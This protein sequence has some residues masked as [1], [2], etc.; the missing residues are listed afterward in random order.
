MKKNLLHVVIA[1]S[2][3]LIGCKT[4]KSNIEWSITLN[5]PGKQPQQVVILPDNFMNGFKLS[6]D[7]GNIK[8]EIQTVSK[9]NY[10]V[11]NATATL[12]KGNEANC[13]LALQADYKSGVAWNYDGEVKRT[14]VFRQSPH[15]VNAWIT[16]S[17][18]KQAMPVI[19][20][21]SADGFSIAVS[22]SPVFYDN[23]TAQ[24]FDIEKKTLL[25]MSGDA[26]L[27]PG[28]KPETMKMGAYNAEKGQIFTPGTVRPYYHKISAN[29]PH[30]FECLV[31]NSKAADLNMLRKDIV[32][33]AAAHWSGGKITDYMG[34][35]AFTVPYMNLRKNE[36]AKSKY[37]VIPSVEYANTQYCRDAF[38]ISTMLTDSMSAEC[39]K[40]ELDSV[41][42]YAEYPLYIPI[43]AYRNQLKGMPVD[44]AKVQQY[45][46][47]IE[48]HI[49]NGSYYSYDVNDGRK[50]FQYWNDCF[51]FD[52]TDVITYN[53][54]LLA[55][56][57]MAAEKM[58]LTL[59]TPSS[60][61]IKRYQSLYNSK[62]GFYPISQ[63]KDSVLSP[64]PLFGDLLAQIYFGTPILS[65]ETIQNHYNKIVQKSKTPFGYKI[66]SDPSG[67]YLSNSAYD[68]GSYQSQINVQNMPVG[69]YQRGGSWTLYDNLFLVDCYLHNIKGAEEELIWRGTLDFKLGATTFECINTKTGEPLKPNM[70]WNSAVYYVVRKLV[71]EKKME[72]TLFTAVNA[73]VN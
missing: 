52:T 44:L 36:T 28:M 8:V 12:L 49:K 15:D 47:V 18:A 33:S 13:F 24:H 6:K 61:A 70:G 42:H 26:G 34:A 25:L 73:I 31:L 35:L 71:D 55:T 72:P 11:L 16:D 57:L 64:D 56:A 9:E 32:L 10:T 58:N 40:S 23:Y 69:F 4:E 19:A 20:M 21:K 7:L 14:E 41:N 3:L 39:L 68:F 62:L 65:T 54:G 50:D 1:L 63:K 46:D 66:V 37:W 5:E 27:T 2:S 22:N 43:W 45:M 53:Q 48:T 60:L 38:W 51:A 17:L 29:N 67:N 30:K 59:K